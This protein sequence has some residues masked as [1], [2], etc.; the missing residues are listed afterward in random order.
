[1]ETE[2]QNKKEDYEEIINT[3]QSK[4]K[5]RWR[6]FAFGFWILALIVV[7]LGIGGALA[8]KTSFT[9]SQIS[10]KNSNAVTVEEEPTPQPDPDRVNV[11]VL[12]LRGEGDPNGGLLTDSLM[13]VS[14]KRSTGQ[15]ALLSIPR[16]LYVT[17]PGETYKEK[18]N[19]AYALGYEKQGAAGGLLYSKIAVSRVTGLNITYAVSFDHMAFKEIVDALGGIDVTL[20]KPFVEDQQWIDGGDTGSSSAFFIQTDT[21]T[22]SK[23]VVTTQKWVFKIPAGTSHLDGNTALYYVRARYS[24][25]DFDRARRQQQVLLAIKNK[26]MSLGVLANPIKISQLMD[27]LGKNV[28]MDAGAGDV[29]N[30]LSLYPKLDTKNITHKVFDTTPAGLLYQSQSS[31][32]AYI[33]LPLGDNFDRIREACRNIFNQNN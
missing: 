1:M 18:I 9:F 12:G 5:P 11:L 22:T 7:M 31:S 23:G 6:R 15:V 32:G 8:Y 29:I 10:V 14:I 2:D 21:A 30:L 25:S 17:M 28:R 24:S 27:S 26:A 20:D 4:P 16:D 19:F 33:L 13:V 3:F